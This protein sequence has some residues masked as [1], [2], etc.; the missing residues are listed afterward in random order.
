MVNFKGLIQI[1]PNAYINTNQIKAIVGNDK[2]T[3]KSP[4]CEGEENIIQGKTEIYMSDN[5]DDKF[6]IHNYDVSKFVKIFEKAEQ[7]NK[8]VDLMA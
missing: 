1:A 3:D 4:F 6:T 8:T 5:R 7:T 2:M